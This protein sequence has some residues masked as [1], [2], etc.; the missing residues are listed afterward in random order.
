MHGGMK[1]YRGAAAAARH[2]VEADRSRADDYYLAEG[3]GLA[4][5]Y[6][7]FPDGLLQ[8]PAMD[9][10]TYERWVAGYDV[11]TDKPKGRLRTDDNAVRFTEIIVNG[12]K[13]WS[14]A[15][16]LH[17]EIAAAY[18]AAQDRAAA[19]IIRWLA[20]H[21][22]TR[23]GPRGRQIQIPVEQIE[24][25]VVHHKTSRAGD[26]HVH[27]HLQINARVWAAGKWR[28]IHT[29]GIRDSL[30][31]INGIGHATVKCD[32]D[33]RAALA[34]HGLRLDEAGEVRNLAHLVG[35]FSARAA[36][37]NRNVDRHEADWR[38]EHPGEEPGP[39]LRRTWDG[40]AWAEARPDKVVPR[41]GTELTRRWVDDLV[42]L[43]ATISAGPTV[44]DPVLPG[45][46]DR[47]DVVET[48]LTRLGA[49][50]SAWNVADVRGEVEQQ[51]AAAGVVTNPAARA[52]LA[53]D[54][55]SRVVDACVRLLE[56]DDVP[57][58]IRY[59]TSPRVLEVEADLT[60]RLTSRGA[61]AAVH[62]EVDSGG[63]DPMQTDVVSAIAGQSPL[64]VIEGAA[65]A[66]KTTTLSAARNALSSQG[67][68]LVVVTPTKKAAEVASQQLGTSA[69]SAA[70]LAHQ[71]GFRWDDDGRWSRVEQT[72]D[73]DARLWPGDVLLVDE[74]GMLDQDTARAL[75][76]IADE[77]GVRLA[78][79][80]D[81]HQLPA[82]GRGGVL[83]LAARWASP[84]A[85]LTL[86]AIHRFADPEYAELSLLM[87][88]GERGGE[89]FDALLARGQIIVHATDVERELALAT[90]GLRTGNERPLLIADTREQASA[91]NAAVRDV[92]V[93][94]DWVNDLRA[95]TTNAGQRI[96]LGDRVA[97]RR[98]DPEL[99]IA[100]RETWTVIGLAPGQELVV[101]S[102]RGR[103]QLPA[104]YVA[105]HLELAYASTAHGAQG[106][107]VT[108]AHVVI[109]DQTSAASAYVGMTRG[110]QNNTAH[111]VADSL[112]EAKRVWLDTFSRDRADLGPAHAAQAALDAMERNGTSP[113][114]LQV[115]LQR[116]VL[117]GSVASSS[118]YESRHE[119]YPRRDDRTIGPAR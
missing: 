28:G 105:E 71:H 107:T 73:L 60:T 62:H 114:S 23:I 113:P 36:Q 44:L 26:P 57:E 43:G 64:L 3:S 32:P 77:S 54:L 117:T 80:G 86:D 82:V 46:V 106:E 76:T 100:N 94:A 70:W 39:R 13:T 58:H 108:S 34:A 95:I 59:L 15:A 101:E 109:S 18:D 51:I 33:F 84:D 8:R 48:V 85:C 89:V 47:A 68:A 72:P 35:A 111:L 11:E 49:K 21:A 41:D 115:A 25:G 102:T 4:D 53:E 45:E 20:Q 79:M 98:N 14:L 17:P 116:A 55:T 52:E 65:G 112:D 12:P 103:R 2:Y 81:R 87:R 67:R 61:V 97:T 91:L 6:I 118:G 38:A 24:A 110:R 119:L 88:T 9:G 10:D 19:E 104:G 96:G 7:A 69:F 30:G 37:I 99:D 90:E 56:R 22:T 50:R 42:E 1:V 5:R 83:D 31:A 63:L 92:L 66:G 29:V 93:S 78:F 27:L 75:L 74:A 16:A 40:L